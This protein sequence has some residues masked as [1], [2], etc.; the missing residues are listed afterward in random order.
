MSATINDTCHQ[1]GSSD[2][3]SRSCDVRGS[4]NTVHV[5]HET[6]C[7][8]IVLTRAN[9]LNALYDSQRNFE[10]RQTEHNRHLLTTDAQLLGELLCKRAERFTARC[11]CVNN[12]WNVA[13]SVLSIHTDAL[14]PCFPSLPKRVVAYIASYHGSQRV[15][16]VNVLPYKYGSQFF[17]LRAHTPLLGSG[18]TERYFGRKCNATML[19]DNELDVNNAAHHI[20]QLEHNLAL[21]LAS[22]RNVLPS[23]SRNA[24]A[25]VMSKCRAIKLSVYGLS[26]REYKGFCSILSNVRAATEAPSRYGDAAKGR[27]SSTQV[28]WNITRHRDIVTF[29]V[30]STK[31]NTQFGTY[32]LALMAEL[33]MMCTSPRTTT[34]THC[35][36]FIRLVCNDLL[37]SASDGCV[38][39]AL[40]GVRCGICNAILLDSLSQQ[41]SST[42]LRDRHLCCMDFNLEKEA[43]IKSYR[44]SRIGARRMGRSSEA[45]KRSKELPTSVYESIHRYIVAAKAGETPPM[46]AADFFREVLPCPYLASSP[47][48]AS[49]ALLVLATF[50]VPSLAK[51]LGG[52]ACL[53]DTVGMALLRVTHPYRLDI[54]ALLSQYFV[55]RDSNSR[56]RSRSTGRMLHAVE[57]HDNIK[58][59]EWREQIAH[60]QEYCT[61]PAGNYGGL[62]IDN[63]AGS[64]I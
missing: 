36:N 26:R 40:N 18:D 43:N 55:Y 63:V 50:A 37:H 30:E 46:D 57:T 39:N 21:C 47:R 13:N 61:L 23:Q 64:S 12:L 1:H 10:V 56:L 20:R 25:Q 41:F 38:V 49:E 42:R 28:Q 62:P 14:L 16:T 6:L 27:C 19:C 35:R 51:M 5:K 32:A 44:K 60:G 59:A 8:H 22:T 54:P 15:P 34:L 4:I 53:A 58:H 33:Q 24:H 17:D 31:W 29:M 45:S 48:E 52:Y 3:V 11:S 7:T 2:D 9:A